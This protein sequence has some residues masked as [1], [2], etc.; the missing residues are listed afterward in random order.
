MDAGT[1]FHWEGRARL[2]V[3]Y[4]D[5]VLPFH[6]GQIPVHRALQPRLLQRHRM[7]R[8]REA[9]HLVERGLRNLRYL[10]QVGA[11]WRT[12]R[13]L[14]S[15][16]PQHRSNGGED[17][18][19]LIMQFARNVE[20]RRFLRGN[21]FLR[22]FAALLRQVRQALEEQPVRPNQI[23]AGEHNGN[24]RRQQKQQHLPLH[25]KVNL[26]DSLPGLLFGFVV[27]DKLSRHRDAP[28]PPGA[29]A[30]DTRICRRGLGF[31]A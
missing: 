2:A 21:Q 11:Q 19:E 14:P 9:A 27:G 24:Q 26:L 22:Q 13:R 1:A 10:H 30:S 18:S 15:R 3:V 20:Q 4:D 17:L 6:Y 25:A 7:Q 16:S 28:A 31:V 23:Q 8:L 12:F 5:S 29:P